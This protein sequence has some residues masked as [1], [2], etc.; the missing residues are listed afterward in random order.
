MSRYLGKKHHVP[1]SLKNTLKNGNLFGNSVHNILKTLKSKKAV[2][3]T[4]LSLGNLF[5]TNSGLSCGL[6]SLI[7]TN[8][9]GWPAL[10]HNHLSK[11]PNFSMSNPLLQLETLVNDHFGGLT[12]LDFSIVF[13][14]ISML[15]L[16]TKPLKAY[17]EI[18]VTTWN[19]T[20]CNREIACNKLS[21]ILK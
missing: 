14:L 10:V 7:Q 11:T 9:H 20:Y 6:V 16:F 18:W 5:H 15:T 21:S 13:N 1:W 19:W 3:F 17:K 4:I 12:F 2:V 8:L